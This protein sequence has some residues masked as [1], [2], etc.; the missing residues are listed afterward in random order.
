MQWTL[1][2]ELRVLLVLGKQFTTELLIQP[3][4]LFQQ[5]PTPPHATPKPPGRLLNTH[6]GSHA[7]QPS[8]HKLIHLLPAFMC[9]L[10]DLNLRQ[11]ELVKSHTRELW[12]ESRR[13]LESVPRSLGQAPP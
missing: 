8:A 10:P 2:T 11:A 7:T 12:E 3:N 6:G 5:T 9:L 1:E 4:F 13:L